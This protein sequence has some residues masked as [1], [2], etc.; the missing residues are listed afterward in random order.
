MRF[1]HRFPIAND[2]VVES[3]LAEVATVFP[4]PPFHPSAHEATLR[5]LEM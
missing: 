2:D 3:K 5:D 4:A 1:V